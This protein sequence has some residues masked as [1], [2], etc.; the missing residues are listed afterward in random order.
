M[1]LILSISIGVFALFSV[2]IRTTQAEESTGS[3]SKPLKELRAEVNQTKKDTRIE[4]INTRQSSKAAMMDQRQDMK[5]SMSAKRAEF[6]EKLQA[7]KDTKKQAVVDKIDVKISTVNSSQTKKW[8]EVLTKLEGILGRIS[9]QG[10]TL[11]SEGLNTT[12]L[13]ASIT[14]AQRAIQTANTSVTTQSQKDYV[15]TITSESALRNTVGSTVSLFRTDLKN[16][17]QTVNAARLAVVKAAEELNELKT[18]TI[19]NEA[20]RA[21]VMEQ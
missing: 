6:K 12:M 15:I 5:A 14:S 3:A 18:A 19:K 17:Q 16:T 9:S 8:E 2:Y 21:A 13:D 4:L 11:K 10:A 1:R 7:I 20:T